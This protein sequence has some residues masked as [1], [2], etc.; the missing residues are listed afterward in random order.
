M[1]MPYRGSSSEHEDHSDNYQTV[2]DPLASKYCGWR[3]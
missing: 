3:T 1:A 2:N